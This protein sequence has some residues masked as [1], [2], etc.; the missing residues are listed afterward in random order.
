MSSPSAQFYHVREVAEQRSV[1]QD[2]VLPW[3]RSGELRATD[4][5]ARPGGRPRW[6]IA[7]ASLN[8]FDLVRASRQAPKIQR[9]R[10]RRDPAVTKVF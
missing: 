9:L 1:N 6:R 3:I 5:S 10:R 7:Q 8:A 2:T 4:C